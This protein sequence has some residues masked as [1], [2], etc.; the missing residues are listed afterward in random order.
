M[1]WDMDWPDEEFKPAADAKQRENVPEGRHRFE[2]V[3]ASED[4]PKLKLSLALVGPDGQPDRRFGWVW[5]NP[6]RDKDWGRRRVA[7]LAAAL[8]LS[9]AE[10]KATA[11]ADLEGRQ[12]EA[13][14]VHKQGD[15][16]VWV[17]VDR[18]HAPAAA[19]T[20]A[21]KPARKPAAAQAL[22]TDDIPF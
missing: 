20:Q 3:R 9:P 15:R 11:V 5:D 7:S 4:G 13:E 19:A 21:A 1:E 17:N 18:Y 16:T 10:W 12:V 6:L 22:A 2:I 8:G 14:I